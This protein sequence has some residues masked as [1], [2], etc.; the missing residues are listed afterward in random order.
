MAMEPTKDF[1][2]QE[3]DQGRRC[4]YKR[5]TQL[6]QI[7]LEN[8]KLQSADIYGFIFYVIRYRYTSAMVSSSLDR[9][10]G[11]L[12][13]VAASSGISSSTSSLP[14]LRRRGFRGVGA[15]P[16]SLSSN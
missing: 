5:S 4:A 11:L 6:L 1:P 9:L 12:T 16:T 3:N 13:G 14:G 10:A 8:C 7:P 15:S 2:N